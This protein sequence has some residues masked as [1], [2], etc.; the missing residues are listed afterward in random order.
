[1]RNA[2]REMRNV[3]AGFVRAEDF[4]EIPHSAFHIPH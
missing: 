1:M 4:F 2:E 3:T